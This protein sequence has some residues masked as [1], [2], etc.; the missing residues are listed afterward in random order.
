MQNIIEPHR[1]AVSFRA[2]GNG[3]FHPYGA[4][5]FFGWL[6]TNSS[7]LTELQ[8][9]LLGASLL[10]FFNGKLRFDGSYSPEGWCRKVHGTRYFFDSVAARALTPKVSVA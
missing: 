10:T 9:E 5:D 4:R 6:A 2:V 7:L 3:I 1:G 8:W